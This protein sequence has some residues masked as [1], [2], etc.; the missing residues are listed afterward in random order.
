MDAVR[1]PMPLYSARFRIVNLM[2]FGANNPI[3]TPRAKLT[4]GTNSNNETVCVHLREGIRPC[5]LEQFLHLIP[6]GVWIRQLL[7][8]VLP[9][10]PQERLDGFLQLSHISSIYSVRCG[11]AQLW[12]LFRYFSRPCF[13]NNSHF[14]LTRVL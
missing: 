3:A 9:H 13:S 1:Y 4:A 6:P 10:L 12:N 7:H 8:I 14:N 2:R 5:M 11:S